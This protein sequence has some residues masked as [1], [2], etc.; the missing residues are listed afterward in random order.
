MILIIT[1]YTPTSLHPSVNSQFIQTD[2]STGLLLLFKYEEEETEAQLKI[3]RSFE[4][5]TKECEDYP[6]EHNDG[7][8]DTIV[9]IG[10]GILRHRSRLRLRP[11]YL[12]VAVPC[13]L[14]CCIYGEATTLT[15]ASPSPSSWS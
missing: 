1:Y 12:Y 13:L 10:E 8:D 11:L 5:M 4:F 7:I 14:A 6:S 3:L 2:V 9:G 15:A